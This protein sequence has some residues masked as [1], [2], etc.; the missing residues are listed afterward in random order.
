VTCQ[1]AGHSPEGRA[2]VF[3]PSSWLSSLWGAEHFG[4]IYG[5]PYA[6]YE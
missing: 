5:G 1:G 6:G 2:G 3:M 4:E